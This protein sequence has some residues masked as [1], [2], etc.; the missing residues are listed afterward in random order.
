[1][2][3]ESDHS[4]LLNQLDAMAASPHYAMRRNVL[5][6]AESLILRQEREIIQLKEQ[7]NAAQKTGASS[8]SMVPDPS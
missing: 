2:G 3:I 6:E 1:M 8:G 7:L 5:R 4:A